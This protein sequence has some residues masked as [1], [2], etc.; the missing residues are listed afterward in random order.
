MD[1]EE[2]GGKE[3]RGTRMK[4][5]MGVAAS[6]YTDTSCPRTRYAV[7]NIYSHMDSWFHRLEFF[8]L[9]F[10]VVDSLMATDF[11]ACLARRNM[12]VGTSSNAIKVWVHQSSLG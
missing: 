3:G 6:I 5:K 12:L 8:E 2:E 9:C 1:E 4:K 10:S 11:N 7:R